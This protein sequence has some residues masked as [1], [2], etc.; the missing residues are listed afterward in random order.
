MWRLLMLV[1]WAGEECKSCVAWHR[2]FVT[3]NVS[4]RVTTSI[5][6]NY[7]RGRSRRVIYR[8]SRYMIMAYHHNKELLGLKIWSKFIGVM[9]YLQPLN[10][11][12]FKNKLK[13]EKFSHSRPGCEQMKTRRRLNERLEASPVQLDRIIDNFTQRDRNSQSL[14][15]WS[16]LTIAILLSSNGVEFRDN[17]LK[18]CF[19]FVAAARQS[20]GGCGIITFQITAQNMDWLTDL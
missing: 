16:G 6:T 4:R 14:L 12:S 8:S 5:C 2:D 7:N 3:Q 15:A 1:A 18:E 19:Y 17:K 13:L 9:S 11:T 10:W 20:V